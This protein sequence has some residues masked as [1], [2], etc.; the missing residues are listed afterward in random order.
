M[1]FISKALRLVSH[2]IS[3]NEDTIKRSLPFILS[4]TSLIFFAADFPAY[5]SSSINTFVCGLS[6]LSVHTSSVISFPIASLTPFFTTLFAM[7]FP[8]E[9]LRSEP[10]NPSTSSFFIFSSKS[11]SRLATP[12]SPIFIRV[13]PLSLSS[14][15]ACKKYLPS[16]QRKASSFITRSVPAL[17][18]K[19][20]KNLLHLSYSVGY[21]L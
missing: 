13:I 4:L 17:P 9:K 8:S 18:V 7:T 19:P 21:S 14:L 3:D 20:L 5:F 16:V 12:G 10:L 11:S 2:A 15:S 6:G 1:H